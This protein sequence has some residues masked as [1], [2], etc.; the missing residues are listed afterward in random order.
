MKVSCPTCSDLVYETAP[1]CPACGSHV[2][3]EHP[4]DIRGVKHFPL[5]YPTAGILTKIVSLLAAVTFVR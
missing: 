5:H 2:Y 3:V 1:A 4:G